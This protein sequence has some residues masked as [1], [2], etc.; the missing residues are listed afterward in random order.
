MLFDIDI[1]LMLFE[2]YYFYLYIVEVVDNFF[3]SQIDKL[4]FVPH[5]FWFIFLFFIFYFLIFSYILPLI[6]QTLKIRELFLNLI[7]NES[8]LYN[9]FFIVI[10]NTYNTN[11]I[12]IFIKAFLLYFRFHRNINNMRSV[13]ILKATTPLLKII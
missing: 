11:I 2:F 7:I 3:M 9:N 13:F 4:N 5:L 6:Y 8:L 12:S 10:S 1:L